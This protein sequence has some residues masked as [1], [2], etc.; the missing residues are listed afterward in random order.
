M[1]SYR[2]PMTRVGTLIFDRSPVRSHSASRLRTVARHRV[3]DLLS[4]FEADELE[5][6]ERAVMLQLG[7]R[8][9]S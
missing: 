1:V 7:L 2:A 5:A 6:L 9:D 3:I 4:Q 8:R